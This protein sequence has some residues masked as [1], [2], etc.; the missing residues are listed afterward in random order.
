MVRE[1]LSVRYCRTKKASPAGSTHRRRFLLGR[2][3]R[4][5]LGWRLV[6]HQSH[7]TG[8]RCNDLAQNQRQVDAGLH[9]W[10]DAVRTSAGRDL[11]VAD[12][13]GVERAGMALQRDVLNIVVVLDRGQDGVRA[14]VA[15]FAVEPAMTHRVPIEL[16]RLLAILGGMAG[17]TAW[18]IDPGA[19]GGIGDGSRAAVAIDTGDAF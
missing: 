5:W 10:V 12:G 3:N 19:A 13:A 16:A 1:A 9:G 8:P 6:G 14:A 18:L 11:R 4:P 2:S 7:M 17:L 15:R